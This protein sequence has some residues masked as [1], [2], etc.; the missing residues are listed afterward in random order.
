MQTSKY[1]NKLIEKKGKPH[2]RTDKDGLDTQPYSGLIRITKIC[3]SK[4]YLDATQYQ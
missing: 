4:Y 1:L 2:V 3:K